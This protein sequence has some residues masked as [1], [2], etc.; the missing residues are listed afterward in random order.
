MLNLNESAVAFVSLEVLF[1]FE[2]DDGRGENIKL[3]NDCAKAIMRDVG[4]EHRD[5]NVGELSQDFVTF[6]VFGGHAFCRWNW[7]EYE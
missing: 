4:E 1:F 6:A 7:C 3:F 5:I 2:V